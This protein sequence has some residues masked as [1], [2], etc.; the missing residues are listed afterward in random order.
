MTEPEARTTSERLQAALTAGTHPDPRQVE[1]L[2]QRCAV[3]PDFYVRDMLTWALTRHDR[4]A[5]VPLLLRELDSEIPQAR[6]Q[7]LHTLSKIGDERAWQ[8]ITPTLLRDTDDEV[9]RTAWRAAAGLV[10]EGG[11]PHLAETLATQFARGDRE[12]RRSLSRAFAMLG[13]AAAPVVERA[14]TAPDPEVR[15]HAIATEQI[16]QN[17]ETGFEAALAEARRVVALRG[18]PLV[19][20]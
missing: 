20:G 3:E 6:S 15:A 8:A 5:T 17:P 14:T 2:V 13:A 16:M 4:S 9:A 10:P 11:E 19:E 1:V 7:A 18:A 12:V